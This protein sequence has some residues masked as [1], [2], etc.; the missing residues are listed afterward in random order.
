[1]AAEPIAEPVHRA[2]VLPRNGLTAL[3]RVIQLGPVLVLTA[4]WVLT[5]FLSPYF[6]TSLNISNLLMASVIVAVLAIGQLLVM[7][8]GAIDLSAGAVLVV[9]GIVGAKFAHGVSDDGVLAVAVMLATGASAGLV[10]GLLVEKARLAS[11]FIVTLGTLSVAQGV[12]FVITDGETATGFPKLVREVGGGYV[13]RIPIA[14]LVVLG[15]AVLAYVMTSRVRWGRW[16]YAMG[17]NREAASRAGIPVQAVSISVFVLSGVTAGIAG[18]FAVGLTDSA[19]PSASFNSLLDAVSAVVIGGAAL[20]G[21]R[22]TVWGTIVGALILGTVH[23]ALN[24]LNVDTNWE[25]IVLGTVLLVAV[26]MDLARGRLETR[27][28]LAAARQGDL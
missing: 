23:N 26:G 6:F 19:P 10:N 16:I 13:G 11:S 22:G 27:L 4:L 8:T 15:V 9:T 7:L 25:P 18:V 17:G 28:R 20:T 12:G 1:M 3:V 24:L 5:S 14:A 2:R 21:G